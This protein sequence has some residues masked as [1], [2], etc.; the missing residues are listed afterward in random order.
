[1]GVIALNKLKFKAM[2][3]NILVP[4]DFSIESLNTLKK[5]MQESTGTFN[6]IL[7]HGAYMSTSITELLFYSKDKLIK[8]LSNDEF[9]EAIHILKN[10]Y[11][12]NIESIRIDIFSGY[13]RAAFNN[14]V[15]ANAID[16]V[17]VATNFQYKFNNK[18]S[19]D[20]LPMAYKAN[21]K[22]HELQIHQE[23]IMPEKG[24]LAEIFYDKMAVG[25]K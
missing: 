23:M 3:K 9:N 12:S 7:L 13:N 16:E 11:D 17:V 1:M 10:K 18:K 5:M 8:E 20:W 22:I 14:Y 25:Q 24:Q 4:I 6:I 21:V 2:G 19:F 15:E